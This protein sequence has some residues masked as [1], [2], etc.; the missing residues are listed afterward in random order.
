M[1]GGPGSSGGRAGSEPC[2]LAVR[3]RSAASCPAEGCPRQEIV[4][5]R[6]GRAPPLPRN[7]TWQVSRLPSLICLPGLPPIGFAPQPRGPQGCCWV[8]PPDRSLP[9]SRF[10]YSERGFSFTLQSSPPC[11]LV[12]TNRNRRRNGGILQNEVKVCQRVSLR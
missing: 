10:R 6:A 1:L 5:D 11:Q 12:L 9:A 2:A 8:K 3:V 4:P 7:S